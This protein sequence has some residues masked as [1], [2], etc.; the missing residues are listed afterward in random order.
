MLPGPEMPHLGKSNFKPPVSFPNEEDSVAMAS[1]NAK[2]ALLTLCC[3]R[4]GLSVVA[5]ILPDNG[6]VFLFDPDQRSA[7]NCRFSYGLSTG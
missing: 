2:T 6:A 4:T 1:R 5:D 7:S 3:N